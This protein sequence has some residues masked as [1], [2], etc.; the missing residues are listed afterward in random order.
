MKKSADPDQTPRSVLFGNVAVPILQIALFHSD[1]R[2][3][4]IAINNRYQDFVQKRGLIS[5]VKNN[6]LDNSPR[7]YQCMCIFVCKD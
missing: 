4:R 2:V 6:L 5:L 7:K 1:V 3:T